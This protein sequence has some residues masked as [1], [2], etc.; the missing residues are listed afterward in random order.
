MNKGVRCMKLMAQRMTC[1]RA[2]SVGL[3]FLW[4]WCLL[5]STERYIE[6]VPVEHVIE[7][8]IFDR[9]D[10]APDINAMLSSYRQVGDIHVMTFHGN[11]D[12]LIDFHHDQTMKYFAS[13]DT[14]NTA[15]IHC[16]L[17][18]CQ[19]KANH[20]FLGRNF[21][22]RETDLL[23][24]LFIPDSG[25]VSFGLIPMI[26][27]RFDEKNPFDPA[28]EAHRQLL[29]HSAAVTVDGM[30]EKGL[31]VT[32]ASVKRQHVEPDTTKP[33]RYLLHLKRNIL[34]H[35]TDVQSAI[36]LASRFNVFDNGLH[37]IAHH[38]LL[39][40]A[41][42]KSV[43]LEWH[44]GRM[45]V[46]E[47]SGDWQIATNTAIYHRSDQELRK[48]CDRY[49]TILRGLTSRPDTV[50][51]KNCMDLL[52]GAKQINQVYHFDSGSMRVSTEWSAVF[53]LTERSVAVCTKHRYDK[54]YQFGL[55]SLADHHDGR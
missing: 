54:V 18:A 16:S 42:G 20:V 9:P 11:F 8:S 38:I 24:G 45:Q 2:I 22:N 15:P 19:D 23:V 41:S 14:L 51:W 32:V 28:S 44:D 33:Y 53:D 39:A 4:M 43:V 52:E 30:N 17:F 50:S 5:C 37:V 29:L 26:E 6:T 27:F 31:A 25:Y 21:D 12:E 34:D 46:L 36:E 1:N 13:Q 47:N 48:K 55:P 7:S 3:I 10:P 40:D 35:A 49:S